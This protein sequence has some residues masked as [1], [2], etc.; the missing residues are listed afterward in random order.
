MKIVVTG[1]AGF[2]GSNTARVLKAAGHSVTAID[3]LSLGDRSNLPSDIPLVVGDAGSRAAWDRISEVDL[4]VHLAGA[5]S[6]PMFD[7]NLED[8]FTNNVMG[9]L[10]VLGAARARGVH[11]VIYASTS[12]IY[13][14]LTPPLVESGSV[15][16]LNFYS[17]SKYCMEQMASM[18]NAEFGMECVGLRFMSVYGP[19]EKHKGSMANLVSQFIWDITAG[20]QPVLYGD[21]RQT[22]DFTSV[23]DV[24]QMI[25]LC[26]EGPQSLGA[27]V[28]N[29]GSGVATSLNELVVMLSHI[30]DVEVKP[31]YVAIPH[32][33]R[34][35]N[36]QQRASLELAARKLGYCPRIRLREGISE[37]LDNLTI[38]AHP[39]I[40]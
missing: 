2:I 32:E 10:S 16:N 35:Y 6:T 27:A 23:W 14:N 9:F 22:R 1:G 38:P 37:I 4:V 30:M 40:T 17:V 21:G 31:R 25:L 7:S 5:S 19:R 13:G 33:R 18:Y 34:A 24:A 11:R 28:F 3:N 20:R 36:L 8:A 15:D 12:L 29:V 39:A 26:A